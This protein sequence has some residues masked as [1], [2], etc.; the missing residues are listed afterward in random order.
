[1]KLEVGQRIELFEVVACSYSTKPFSIGQWRP[2]EIGTNRSYVY[3]FN[4]KYNILEGL[5]MATKGNTKF[6]EECKAVGA[7]IIKSIKP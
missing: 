4:D 7:M 3:L 6:Q 1:M 2:A 5:Y